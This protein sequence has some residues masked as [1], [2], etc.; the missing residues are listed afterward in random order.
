MVEGIV[1]VPAT[2]T[3]DTRAIRDRNGLPPESGFAYQWVRVNGG[4]EREI[5][6]ATGSAYT[7]T[8]AD[9]GKRIKVRV[10]FTDNAVSSE[11]VVSDAFPSGMASILPRGVCRV[12]A[13]PSGTT[14][15][16]QGTVTVG[17]DGTDTFGFVS[18]FAGS[19][20]DSDFM[21]DG[22][23]YTIDIASEGRNGS[24]SFRFSLDRQLPAN[25]KPRLL[26]YLCDQPVNFSESSYSSRSH[27]YDWTR[28]GVDWSTHVMRRI[29]LG[30]DG[31]TAPTLRSATVDGTEL[32]LTFN[33]NLDDSSVPAASV[34]T[35]S[36]EGAPVTLAST[37]AVLVR[38]RMVSLLLERAIT[39]GTATVS[40][41]KPASGNTLRDGAH[42]EV[43]GFADQA[44]TINAEPMASDGRVRTREDVP[45][46]FT[47]GDFNFNDNDT[48]HALMSVSVLEPPAR[49]T[50][51]LNGA[52]LADETEV[53]RAEIDS[54]R[55]V[56]TPAA[57][58]HGDAYTSFT[59]EVSDGTA[60]SDSYTMTID[61]T[62]ENDEAA[63]APAI[64]GT[65]RVGQTLRV[66]TDGAVDFDGLTDTIFSYQWIWV[67]QSTEIEIADATEPTHNLTTDD[68]GKKFKVR[69]SFNDDDGNPETLTSAVFPASGVVTT[70]II[71]GSSTNMLVSNINRL[72]EHGSAQES[73][74]LVWSGDLYANKFTTG[75]NT[76]GYELNS[77]EIVLLN[78]VNSNGVLLR[79]VPEASS[80]PNF[81]SRSSVITLRTPNPIANGSSRFLAPPGTILDASRS[82]YVAFTGLNGNVM[83]K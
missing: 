24:G 70:N 30:R 61:V 31:G 63:G 35:V 14:E 53:T 71:I 55:L 5:G 49:G 40:Y 42:N 80:R 1:R 23:S 33:E 9:A 81:N 46:T 83:R 76:K 13:Y 26:L 43:E 57:H 58:A 82:Y 7:L 38:G 2:L 6:G 12:P 4:I 45:Y 54:G 20:S 16:W 32:V 79:V 29:Y 17:R 50:L 73:Q 68:V 27:H 77:V 64:W 28:T 11:P 52:A 67:N 19:L 56:F 51:T 39:A 37:D 18:E 47:A 22:T 62:A 44:V 78:R 34:F 41:T 75:G 48:G 3:A 8:D 59:F 36:A 69:V 66:L 65:A 72:D 25:E 60:K 15:I 10:S 74:T 21:I